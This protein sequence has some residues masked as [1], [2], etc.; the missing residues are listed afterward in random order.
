MCHSAWWERW[1]DRDRLLEKLREKD[2]LIVELKKA[3]L[4]KDQHVCRLETALAQQDRSLEAQLSEL[5]KTAP[6]AP[7]GG[8][9]VAPQRDQRARRL[10][11]DPPQQNRPLPTRQPDRQ[12]TDPAKANGGAAVQDDLPSWFQLLNM[13]RSVGLFADGWLSQE[14]W[15]VFA[16]PQSGREITLTFYLPKDDSETKELG[17]KPNFAD[18]ETITI[19][20]GAP[21]DYTYAIPDDLQTAPTFLI[22]AA[23]PEPRSRS[24]ELRN[25]GVLVG[26]IRVQ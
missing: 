12:K 6:A 26:K 16:A 25:L 5:Q 22:T 20:R 19:D 17:V 10:E 18:A 23:A 14:A 24:D 7:N 4:E 11:M 2:E 21:V 9:K 15:L 1:V 8:L 13:D 3:L